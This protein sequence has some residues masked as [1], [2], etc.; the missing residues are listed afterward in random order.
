[1]K[2]TGTNT[3]MD[4]EHAGKKA[5]FA[6]E[7]MCSSEGKIT[8]F[9]AIADSMQWLPPNEHQPVSE[10]EKSALIEAVNAENKKLKIKILFE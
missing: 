5:R 1:M 8:G 4:V 9:C 6:G 10:V 7:F 3:Y 2:I